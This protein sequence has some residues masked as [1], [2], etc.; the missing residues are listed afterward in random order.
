MRAR[1]DP[2]DLAAAVQFLLA[3]RQ[4]ATACECV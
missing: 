4:P 1:I 2:Q 3:R